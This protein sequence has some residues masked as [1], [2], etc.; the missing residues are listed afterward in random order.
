MCSSDTNRHALSRAVD[1]DAAAP[2]TDRVRAPIAEEGENLCPTPQSPWMGVS[3]RL[4]RLP[5]REAATRPPTRLHPRHAIGGTA[6]NP[7][8]HGSARDRFH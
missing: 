2:P 1:P 3:R 4:R 6:P 8:R 7:T 5:A